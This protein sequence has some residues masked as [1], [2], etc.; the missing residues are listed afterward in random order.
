MKLALQIIGWP[1]LVLTCV[2]VLYLLCSAIGGG[3]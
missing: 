1:V 2:G 3:S